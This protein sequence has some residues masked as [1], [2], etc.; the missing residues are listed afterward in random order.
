MNISN[1]DWLKIFG[2]SGK[3]RTKMTIRYAT[4]SFKLLSNHLLNTWQIYMLTFSVLGFLVI[5][6]MSLR[7]GLQAP[8]AFPYNF[9]LCILFR[10]TKYKQGLLY[11][12]I[13][14]N[15]S[16]W[17][18]TNHVNCITILLHFLF[19]QFHF[20]WG[21]W[22]WQCSFTINMYLSCFLMGKV[23]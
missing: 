19:F 1:P 18:H 8:Y 21:S 4:Y 17:K 3:S 23:E 6:H 10:L 2:F 11:F 15:I 12:K 5:F 13:I 14:Q 20:F 9:L 16:F 22:Y 7:S